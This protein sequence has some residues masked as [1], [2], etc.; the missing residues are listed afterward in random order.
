MTPA[1]TL[2]PLRVQLEEAEQALESMMVYGPDEDETQLSWSRSAKFKAEEIERLRSR[3][4]DT[5]C[6]G[7]GWLW[8]ESELKDGM[9]P[10]CWKK[11]EAAEAR[12][13]R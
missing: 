12:E 6:S 9:C 7:C 2:K 3:L 8:M 1:P 10:E 13:E 5:E 4:L 11:L